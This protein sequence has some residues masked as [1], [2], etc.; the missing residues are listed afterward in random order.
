MC[1]RSSG[2]FLDCYVSDGEMKSFTHKRRTFYKRERYN[3]DCLYKRRKLLDRSSIVTFDGVFSGESNSSSPQKNMN[4]D[5]N[6]SIAMMHGG[7]LLH[8][9]L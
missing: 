5:R 1:T 9:Y 6:G 2:D 8:L 3:S 4:S 7:L